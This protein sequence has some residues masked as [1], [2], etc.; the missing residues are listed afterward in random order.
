[1]NEVIIKQELKKL[2]K[3]RS[4]EVK[5]EWDNL[6]KEKERV[7]SRS[8]SYL[9][10]VT[11]LLKKQK[12]DLAPIYA[13]DEKKKKAAE[14][15][16]KKT[17]EKLMN[18]FTEIPFEDSSLL[19]GL[20]YSSHSY[21]VLY[22]Y[23]THYYRNGVLTVDGQN[24]GNLDP[25]ARAVGDGIGWG[26]A[27]G[28][29]DMIEIIDRWYMFRPD[30]TGGYTFQIVVPFHGFYIVR[31]DDG[32]WTSKDAWVKIDVTTDVYQFYWM[33]D[34]RNPIMSIGDENI[35]TNGRLDR[36][37]FLRNLGLLGGGDWAYLMVRQRL[38]S[39]AKGSGSLAELNFGDG[40]ANYLAAP[41][42]F[43]F[44]P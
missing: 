25:V 3:Q 5:S 28:Y 4:A 18:E 19:H 15:E 23:Y 8:K 38:E 39:H 34:I 44:G 13:L 14:Q 40:N 10:E 21:Q 17:R 26:I 37:F 16:T 27:R 32:F 24:I 31:A 36:S 33:S 29:S 11:G 42:V 30:V 12:I 7:S 2:F 41:F 6:M 43:V 9:D 35:D 22:H 20:T 1:M